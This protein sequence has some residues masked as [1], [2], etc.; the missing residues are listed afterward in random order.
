MRNDQELSNH[1]RD[2]FIMAGIANCEWENLTHRELF[3]RYQGRIMY[4][5][6]HTSNIVAKIHNANVSTK[7]D[8][9]SPDFFHPYKR[10]SK[11]TVITKDI[12][13]SQFKQLAKRA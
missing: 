5:W 1:W 12:L 10:A 6:D 8:L 7:S 13:H 9:K 2:V 4:D 3:L 11:G